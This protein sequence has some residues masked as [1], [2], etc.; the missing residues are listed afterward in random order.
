MCIYVKIHQQYE[1]L[2]SIIYSRIEAYLRPRHVNHSERFCRISKY[3]SRIS[4]AC[5]SEFMKFRETVPR[6]HRVTFHRR[7]QLSIG[8][9]YSVMA[10]IYVAGCTY[11]RL[12]KADLRYVMRNIPSNHLLVHLSSFVFRLS[13]VCQSS[14]FRQNG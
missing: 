6:T 9:V 13:I 12:P 14:G 3:E 5:G 2:L 10:S 11:R 8:L 4:A 1:G 7:L